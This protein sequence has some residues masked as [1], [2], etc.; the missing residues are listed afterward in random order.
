MVV[1][2]FDGRDGAV[3][4]K[5][6]SQCLHRS[7]RSTT[8]TNNHHETL[9]TP[10]QVGL[11]TLVTDFVAVK[12]DGRDGAVVLEGLSQCLECGTK[13][14]TLRGNQ[15][16]VLLTPTA[17]LCIPVTNL[18]QPQID[19][20]PAQFNRRD[21]AVLIEGL[22]QLLDCVTEG[23]QILSTPSSTSIQAFS[24]KRGCSGSSICGPSFSDPVACQ[25]ES[26]LKFVKGVRGPPKTIAEQ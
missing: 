6:L 24:F 10:M 11:S 1:A 19:G 2:K 22:S 18:V 13:S 20:V 9:L 5:G 14:N 25:Q 21:G 23:I 15:R 16:E 4:T 17:G 12:V 3:L 8:L 26:C 7:T